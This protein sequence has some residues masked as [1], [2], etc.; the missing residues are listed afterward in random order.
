MMVRDL[1]QALTVHCCCLPGASN[2]CQVPELN[3]WDVDCGLW[4]H[5]V[6][7]PSCWLGRGCRFARWSAGASL[8]H[9]DGEGADAG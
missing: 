2:T 6:W 7:W 5:E 8:L 3:D 4:N 1:G 9:H